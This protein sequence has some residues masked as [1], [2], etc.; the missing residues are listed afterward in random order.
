MAEFTSLRDAIADLVP[1]GSVVA[2]EGF[3]HLIP[4]AAGHEVIRQEKRDLTLVRMTPDVIY[5]Q[6]IG[7][8]CAA[9][10]VFSW[11]GNPGV[12]SLH[13]LRDAVE[14]GHPRPLDTEE[15]THA[16]MAARYAAG[17]SGLPFGI[18]L[19][20]IGTDLMEHTNVATVTSPFGGEEVAAV[21]ALNPDVA[22]IHAQQADRAG[23]VGIWG[24]TGVQREV[25]LAADRVVVTVEEVVEAIDFRGPN[26]VVLPS[27]T[28]DAITEVPRGSHPSYS[29][30][31]TERDNAFYT[32]WD[33]ISRDRDL[34]A[35]WIETYVTGADDFST[36]L[37]AVDD[38]T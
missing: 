30:G 23:N 25:A 35:Q 6:L 37:D 38:G 15:H 24:I 14:N 32:R 27:W 8:G 7:A 1:D 22:V 18:L 29:M 17:A 12:G 4:V 16:G 5:D 33:A 13:R 28:V 10:L 21:P 36:Y 20:Y 3:T 11:G 9:R 19:G 34:F 2:M 31:Y 26:G